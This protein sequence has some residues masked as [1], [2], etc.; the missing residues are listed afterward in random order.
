MRHIVDA[1]D[2][3]QRA[4]ILTSRYAL[5]FMLDLFSTEQYVE[6]DGVY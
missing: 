1:V 6:K 4:I 3:N 2:R 5:I